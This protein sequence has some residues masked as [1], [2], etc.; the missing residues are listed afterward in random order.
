MYDAQYDVL[1]LRRFQITF[2]LCALEKK[3]EL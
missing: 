2:K 3:N 1:M